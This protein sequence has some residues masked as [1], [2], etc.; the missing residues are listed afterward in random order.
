MHMSR[1]KIRKSYPST[2]VSG[3]LGVGDIDSARISDHRGS[4]DVDRDPRSTIKTLYS[5]ELLPQVAERHTVKSMSYR[6]TL[7]DPPGVRWPLSCAASVVP[8]VAR[9]DVENKT[10][11]H[12]RLYTSLARVTSGSNSS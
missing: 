1:L 8:V 6:E 7:L 12:P 4:G 10:Q 5:A 2:S 11:A 9:D 3:E